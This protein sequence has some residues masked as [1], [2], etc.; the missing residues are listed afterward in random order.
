MKNVF[1][2]QSSMPVMTQAVLVA[3]YYGVDNE[4]ATIGAAVTTILSLLVIPIYL[5][6]FR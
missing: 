2:I 1:I 4:L 6:I 5:I 3:K